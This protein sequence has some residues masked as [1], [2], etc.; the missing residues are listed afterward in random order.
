MSNS[1][2]AGKAEVELGPGIRRPRRNL[3]R[4][5]VLVGFLLIAPAMLLV[6]AVLVYPT[7]FNLGIAMQEW[8]WSTPAAAE[9]P[10]VGLDNFLQ[11]FRS[12]RFWNSVSISLVLVI[13]GVI[14]Q[15]VLGLAMAVM[16]NRKFFAQRV[17]R[18][19]FILPMV[20]APIVIGI[21]WRYLLSSNFGVLNYAIGQL[22]L[23]APRWLSDPAL[24]LPILLLVDTWTW[25][26]FVTVILLAALQQVPQEVVEAAEVDGANA[27]QRFFYI[28]LPMLRPASVIVLLL[29][30]TEIFRAFDVIYVLT[31][32]GPGRSTEVLGMLLYRTAFVEGNLGLA[33]ALSVFIGV[34]GMIIGTVFIRAIRTEVRLF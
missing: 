14:I 30:S 20:L 7:I 9:K 15:Y 25:L 13:G 17:F 11:L 29:R 8:S 6:F 16:L 4:Q 5:E 28:V 2:L 32:G 12:A 27:R 33:A 3:S 22:G 31:G 26:P 21:Q 10:F 1:V 34:I 18:A 23:Q 24:A 19:I